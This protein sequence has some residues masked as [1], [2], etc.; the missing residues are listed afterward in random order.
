MRIFGY[1]AQKQHMTSPF[2]I[3]ESGATVPGCLLLAPTSLRICAHMEVS[4]P[5][6]EPELRITIMLWRL[7]SVSY[8]IL[9]MHVIGILKI[10]RTDS[11]RVS[12]VI[13]TH[14]HITPPLHECVTVH[15][16]VHYDSPEFNCWNI[17]TYKLCDTI[18]QLQAFSVARLAWNKTNWLV[19]LSL[20]CKILR[21]LVGLLFGLL[22]YFCFKL[23]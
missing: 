1:F 18:W 10:P 19:S 14:T 23:W 8:S 7:T 4:Q 21:W 11:A 3:R 5:D 9:R 22:W 15:I 13:S 16:T 6:V 2:P 17:P 20:A 12:T